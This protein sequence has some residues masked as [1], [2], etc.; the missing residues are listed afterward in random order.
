MPVFG[1]RPQDLSK[2]EGGIILVDTLP[3]RGKPGALYQTPD[4]NIYTWFV[5]SHKEI[6]PPTSLEVGKT[7]T[8]RDS[9]PGE[10]FED[11]F[12]TIFIPTPSPEQEDI[13]HYADVHFSVELDTPILQGLNKLSIG[14]NIGGEIGTNEGVV[15]FTTVELLEEPVDVTISMPFEGIT[16]SVI[17][18]VANNVEEPYE[19]TIT[20]ELVTKFAEAS[21]GSC[22]LND[23]AFLFVGEETTVL[24]AE[25]FIK[26]NGSII[27]DYDEVF[28]GE[29]AEIYLDTEGYDAKSIYYTVISGGSVVMESNGYFQCMNSYHYYNTKTGDKE[30]QINPNGKLS[31]LY[32]TL[33]NSTGAKN[34]YEHGKVLEVAPKEKEPTKE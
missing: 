29:Y 19:V 2:V 10:E 16:P 34:G 14:C 25:C 8:L 28:T 1:I 21:Q 31:S 3:E 33:A 20:Q 11:K 12:E 5:A 22:T 23:F 32:V 6:V 4:G 27:I 7:Y 26:V 9:I 18:P 24:D 30:L 13:G 15:S 17:F